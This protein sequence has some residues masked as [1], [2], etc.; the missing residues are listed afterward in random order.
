MK[1]F[2][3]YLKEAVEAKLNE[4]KD[5]DINRWNGKDNFKS[6]NFDKIDDEYPRLYY[7][8]RGKKTDKIYARHEEDEPGDWIAVGKDMRSCVKKLLNNFSQDYS[9]IGWCFS[10]HGGFYYDEDADGDAERSEPIVMLPCIVEIKTVEE[11]EE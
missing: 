8:Y 1:K 3:E 10:R 11:D 2:N 6:S 7:F 9:E 4:A 5:N